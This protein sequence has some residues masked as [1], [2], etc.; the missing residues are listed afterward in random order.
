MHL[1]GSH[2]KNPDL[3]ADNDGSADENGDN[4]LDGDD[5]NGVDM[6]EIHNRVHSATPCN[7]LRVQ[8][9]LWKVAKHCKCTSLVLTTRILI[10]LLMMVMKMVRDET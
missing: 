9:L 2:D 7:V 1:V 6:T 10:Y 5:D 3:F 4:K 8:S